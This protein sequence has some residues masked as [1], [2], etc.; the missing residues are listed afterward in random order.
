MKKEYTLKLLFTVIMVL[1]FPLISYAKPVLFYSDIISGPNTGGRNNNGVFVRVF[2]KGFG[3]SRGTSTVSV[4]GGLVASYPTWSD[5][6]ISFQLGSN[7]K[8]GSI[9][10]STPQGA[11]NSL[12][13]TV[14]SGRIFFVD[15]NSPSTPG[16]GTFE[17]PWR[18]PRNF[19]E[20]AQPGDTLYM[21]AGTYNGEYGITGWG[22][23]FGLRVGTG[24]SRTRSG[25]QAMP[26]A[27]LAYPGENVKLSAPGPTGP[28]RAFRLAANTSSEEMVHWIT[29]ANFSMESYGACIANGGNPGIYGKGWRIVNNDCNG[30]TMT[31]Q[32]QTGSIVPGGDYSKVLG[33]KIHGGRTGDKLDHAIYSQACG[34]DVEIAWNHIYDNNFASGPLVS[35]NYEGTRCD[36]EGYA[37]NIYVHDNIIDATNYPSRGIYPFNQSYTTG[38]PVVPVTYVYNNIC[39]NCG[40]PGAD[41]ALVMRNGAMEAYN[42]TFYNTRTYCLEISGPT[43]NVAYL[44]FK[45]NICHMRTTASGYTRY[46]SDAP[47]R[48]AEKNIYSGFGDY[49]GTMDTAPINADPAFVN[50]A[51]GN[52]HLSAGS[53]AIGTGS[54]AIGSYVTRDFDGNVRSKSISDIGAYLYNSSVPNPPQNLRFK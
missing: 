24:S 8:T 50:A 35:I 46:E 41:G 34:D 29:I 26:I 3:A 16:S 12:P 2:G 4:G 36:W 5:T 13:F 15:I 7:A 53:P 44:K 39:I 49:N 40:G 51:G 20:G 25:T 28:V 23:V 14:R 43:P 54:T 27:Y 6:E 1:A 32:A 18:S 47:V 52:F 22:A 45:N 38:D 33:N 9:V 31:V 42:N 37:G 21:R 19:L 17:D 48:D 11:S 10:V 30:L